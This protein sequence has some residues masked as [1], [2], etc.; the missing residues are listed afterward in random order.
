MR[1]YEY[2]LFRIYMFYKNKMKDKRNLLLP[3]SFVSTTI[4]CINLMTI[5]FYFIYKDLVPAVPNKYFIV[6]FMIIIWL[7]NYYSIIIKENFLKRNFHIDVKG[8]I[9]VIGYIIMTFFIF[10]VLAN[11]NR[12]KI[13]KYREINKIKLESHQ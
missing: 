12:E 13:F 3:T 7:I 11:Y 5:Y 9:A 4:I 10:I 6:G 8:G 2:F 1:A